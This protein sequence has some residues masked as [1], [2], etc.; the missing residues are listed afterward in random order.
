MK[1]DK[2]YSVLSSFEYNFFIN[3]FLL[4]LMD[5]LEQLRRRIKVFTFV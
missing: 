4:V 5:Q 3:M 2:H 1:D